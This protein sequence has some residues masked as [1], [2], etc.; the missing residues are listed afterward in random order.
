MTPLKPSQHKAYSDSWLLF[1]PIRPWRTWRGGE[2]DPQTY[3]DHAGYKEAIGDQLKF[4]ITPAVFRD[5]IA[6][7]YEANKVCQ[8][9]HAIGWLHPKPRGVGNTSS[10]ARGATT[11]SSA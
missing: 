8:V 5:E 4:W 6:R 2:G 10:K 7:G 1:C 11:S 9:L 3:T